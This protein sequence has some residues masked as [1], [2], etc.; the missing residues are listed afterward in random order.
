MDGLGCLQVSLR[1]GKT[2]E[3]LFYFQLFNYSEKILNAK[4]LEI[5][6]FLEHKTIA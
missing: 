1:Q 6:A 3:C 5:N 4:F 2:E